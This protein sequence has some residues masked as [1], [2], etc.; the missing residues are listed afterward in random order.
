MHKRTPINMIFLLLASFTYICSYS[1]LKYICLE[2]KL[3]IIQELKYL[4]YLYIII[5]EISIYI[6]YIQA[7][8]STLL[9][10]SKDMGITRTY[11]LR[12]MV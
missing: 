8:V 9:L 4:N 7:K 12:I 6:L 11:Y 1:S 2:I 10:L 3:K 5:T